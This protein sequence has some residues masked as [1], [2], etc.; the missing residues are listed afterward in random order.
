MGLDGLLFGWGSARPGGEG[1]IFLLLGASGSGKTTLASCL[2]DLDIPE[3][4]SHTTRQPRKG[5]VEGQTYYFVSRMQFEHTHMVEST[6]YAGNLYGTSEWEVDRVLSSGG[7][8]FAIVDKHG[9]QAFK[10]IYGELC[11]VIYIWVSP[12]EA[13]GRMSV[14]GDSTEEVA[15]RVQH[16]IATG[17]FNNMDIADYCIINKDLDASLRQLSAII[18]EG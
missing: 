4:I 9:A 14:R 11:K 2:R 8:A 7:S 12:L 6:E 5:E 13:A 3:L 18:R 15:K 10:E 16:A 17:E 1:V